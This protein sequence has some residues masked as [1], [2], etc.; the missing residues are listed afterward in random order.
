MDPTKEKNKLYPDG[1]A[2]RGAPF[3][4]LDW[5]HGADVIANHSGLGAQM[6]SWD[7]AAIIHVAHGR[8]R[9]SFIG[10]RDGG[11]PVVSYQ[12]SKDRDPRFKAVVTFWPQH[13]NYLKAVFQRVKVYLVPAPCDL[14]FWHPGPKAAKFPGGAKINAVCTDGFRGDVDP[15]EAIIAFLN[16]SRHRDAKLH[17]F[18]V[19]KQN[20]RGWAALFKVMRD[21]GVMGAKEAWVSQD[22]LRH[23]Y[24]SAAF[25]ITSH[26]IDTR[27]VREAMACG[28][29]VMRCSGGL[30][31]DT[32]VRS[33]VRASAE[34]RFDPA[35]TAT[36]FA[37][38]AQRAIGG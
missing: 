3:A 21:R 28:C 2:D 22:K 14:D 1:D 6:E 36:E 18:G 13:Q 8:A 37:R 35:K 29:P 15:Y 19:G 33:E 38:I 16:W 7:D 17:L 20:N 25:L 26:E 32:M 10:E 30:I 4:D 24:R 11:T 5:A 34:M 9:H 31:V 27:S 23:I 12:I